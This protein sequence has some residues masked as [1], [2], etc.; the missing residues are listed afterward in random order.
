[1]TAIVSQ[2]VPAQEIGCMA[3]TVD[4]EQPGLNALEAALTDACERYRVAKLVVKEAKACAKAAKKDRRRARKALIEAQSLP[5]RAASTGD[6]PQQAS[7]LE[8]STPSSVAGRKKI[9][10]VVT[11]DTAATI[12]ESSEQAVKRPSEKSR[13][14]MNE[15]PTADDADVTS[16]SLSRG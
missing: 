9:R 8:P 4:D 7:F 5:E 6:N 16:T 15:S 12:E 10:R 3:S 2:D 11:S 14:S 13:V 1:M